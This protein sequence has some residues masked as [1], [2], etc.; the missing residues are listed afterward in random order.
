[1]FVMIENKART[2]IDPLTDSRLFIKS[3]PEI[4]YYRAIFTSPDVA[5][6]FTI[7]IRQKFADK[8]VA[9][10]NPS[11]PTL[12]I[13]AGDLN[14]AF[15]KQGLVDFEQNTLLIEHVIRMMCF[16]NRNRRLSPAPFFWSNYNTIR[17]YNY[18]YRML[19]DEMLL[20]LS[21][22]PEQGLLHSGGVAHG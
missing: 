20:S 22:D 19:S 16:I 4:E 11:N 14:D 2:A 10:N 15:V 12:L 8:P 3:G 9:A 6:N 5:L 21:L 17:W 13:Y 18:R 1:M 7:E